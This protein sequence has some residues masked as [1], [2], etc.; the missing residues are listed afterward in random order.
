MIERSHLFNGRFKHNLDQWTASNAVY[1]AGDGDDHYGVAVLSVGG[2]ISQ[3]F[4]I[5][6]VRSYAI[7][8]AVKAVGSALSTGQCTLTI[9]DGNGNAVKTQNLTGTADTWTDNDISAGLAPG[10]TY[11]FK[12]TNASAAG[13]VRI[14][15]VWL[16]FVPMTRANMAVRVSEKI[17]RLATDRSL[18][19]AV[20]GTKT[21]GDYTYAVDAGLRAVGAINPETGLPDVRYLDEEN[22]QTA[23][24]YI[25]T[26]IVEQLKL[27]YAVEVDIRV[28]QRA[29]SLSQISKALGDMS[30]QKS[31]GRV[32]M[33]R[34]KY[35]RREDFEL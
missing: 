23:L 3:T 16:W 33:R 4:T 26:E 1:S 10:T 2:Y 25:T 6:R 28:G 19:T 27:D 15:D 30:G 13:D 21:E 5:P 34:M 8:V 22:L 24:D 7:H 17:G 12:I 14:D 11:T 18:S 31:G 32:V 20:S 35:P 29:E 9:T